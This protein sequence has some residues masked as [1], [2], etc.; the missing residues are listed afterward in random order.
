M[1][2]IRRQP[3]SMELVEEH[4]GVAP[5]ADIGHNNPPPADMARDEFDARL[6]ALLSEKGINRSRFDDVVGA[7]DRAQADDDEQAG[8][9]GDLIRQ[10][11][12]LSGLVDQA[13]KEVKAPYLEAG[14]AVDDKKNVLNT[15]LDAA[16]RKVDAVL[17]AHVQRKE[18]KAREEQ[19]RRDEEERAR[20]AEQERIAREQEAERRRLAEEAA[21]QG[22]PP[23]P[24]PEPIAEPEPEVIHQAAPTAVRSDL[25]TTVSGRKVWT[26]EITNYEDAVLA[27][28]HNDIVRQAVEKAIGAQVR[29]GVRDIAG[30][31]IFQSIKADVR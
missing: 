5:A 28:A 2:Q 30:V 23:P 4:F 22:A 21:A 7:A 1:A 24:E 3:T 6:D 9:C 25:G 29:A 27:L 13:H 17:S 31:R 14:R 12:S 18:A 15:P 8:R 10:I 20:R 16:R 19:R 26:H 11:R